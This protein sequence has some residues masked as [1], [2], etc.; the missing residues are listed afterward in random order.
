VG[1][2]GS[3]TL[4]HIKKNSL[5]RHQVARCQSS[6]EERKDEIDVSWKEQLQQKT[7]VKET[8]E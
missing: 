6:T 1:R 2:E 7:T 4:K 3:H 5:K 8:G